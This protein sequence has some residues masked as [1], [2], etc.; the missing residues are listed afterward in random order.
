MTVSTPWLSDIFGMDYEEED[1]KWDIKDDMS[2]S[3]KEEVP[4]LVRPSLPFL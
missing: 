1:K 3:R 4:S 2:C